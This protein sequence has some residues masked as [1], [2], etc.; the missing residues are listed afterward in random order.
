MGRVRL[1][2]DFLDDKDQAS[3]CPDFLVGDDLVAQ[4]TF[5]ITKPQRLRLRIG[6]DAPIV[7]LYLLFAGE[8]TVD[9]WNS[10]RRAP[11]P[12]RENDLR[13][14]ANG[15]PCPCRRE[16]LPLPLTLIPPQTRAVF[17]A[18]ILAFFP[19]EPM[20]PES[21]LVIWLP[22][23]PHQLARVIVSTEKLAMQAAPALPLPA[24]PSQPK[25]SSQLPK[26]GD[27]LTETLQKRTS[28]PTVAD[29]HQLHL[30]FRGG[31]LLGQV[32]GPIAYQ[33]WDGG[34][35]LRQWGEGTDR[36]LYRLAT[37]WLQTNEMHGQQRL[38]R[39]YLPIAEVELSAG[40]K[41]LTQ[42]VFVDHEHCLRARY[43]LRGLTKERIEDEVWQCGL[44]GCENDPKALAQ[45]ISRQ[46]GDA[47]ELTIL[48]SQRTGTRSLE[49]VDG[50]VRLDV[51]IPL[52]EH[53]PLRSF[54]EAEQLLSADCEAYLQRGA[55]LSFP[56]PLFAKLWRALLLHNRLFVQGGVMRYGLFPGV[57]D[58]GVFGVEEGWNIVALSQYGHH[59]EAARVLERTFFDP[60]FLAKEGQHHQYRNGLALTYA[61]D[62]YALSQD[63]TLLARL[64]PQIAESAEW[65]AAS[66][67]STQQLVDGNRPIHFGLLPKHTYGGDLT[68]PAFGLYGSSACWRGLRDA[69][70]LAKI[71]GDGRADSW[72]AQAAETRRNLL[73]AA[74]RSFQ[75]N[76]TPPYLP[77]RTDE[78]G[79]TPSAGDYHQLFASLILET[80]LFGWHGRF[81]HE[82]TDYLEQT[83]RQVLQ[84]ARF[85][86]WFGRLGVDAEYSRGTQLCALHRRD[87]SRFYLG[88]LGQVALSCD[89]YTF[90]SPETAIVLFDDTEW[91]DRM[92]ALSQ[93]PCRFDSDPCSAGTAVMLQYLRFLVVSEERDEDDLPTGTVLVGAALPKSYFAPGQHFAAHKLPTLF[94]PISVDCESSERETVYRIAYN[95]AFTV[96]LF[97]FDRAGQHRTHKTQLPVPAQTTRPHTP[98]VVRLFR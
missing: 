62:V 34:I 13:L 22:A 65:I 94:G 81:S 56:D 71:T 49:R 93:Q 74:E 45:R 95:Q 46:P 96:E 60:Q 26:H 69:G 70:R 32:E 1:Q 38:Q 91:R 63:R 29:L 35:V 44:S 87:F 67:R 80:A 78:T 30:P 76:G 77:F 82:I 16:T 88:L 21:E 53:S 2:A 36:A 85:D 25:S 5:A 58:G 42:R 10:W 50:G 97:Y 73:L 54:E 98:T 41:T 75:H 8:G 14:D 7:A 59:D 17:P 15:S 64:W 19:D 18:T 61:A 6:A 89:P 57:Y 84:V 37:D 39:G 28:D 43:T 48:L 72:L 66:F 3:D 11:R 33:L 90:V 83:G 20:A 92:K 79:K 51:T 55:E 9:T 40:D 47:Q 4:K 86:D 24:A 52:A 31:A 12:P 27:Q 68:T 23:G